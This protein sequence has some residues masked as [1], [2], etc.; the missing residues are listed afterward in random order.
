MTNP[1]NQ[2]QQML[3]QAAAAAAA[4]P[5][6]TP[7]KAPPAKAPTAAAKPAAAPK[8]PPKAPAPPKAVVRE[9]ESA[10]AADVA[11]EQPQTTTVSSTDF[12]TLPDTVETTIT[13]PPL[14]TIE[15]NPEFADGNCFKLS[16]YATGCLDCAAMVAEDPSHELIDRRD[17]NCHYLNGNTHCPAQYFK[18]EFI[19]RRVIWDRKV[20][21]VKELPEGSSER[22]NAAIAL[23][24]KAAKI[25]DDDL[26]N[27]VMYQ[28]GI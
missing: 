24:T 1:T 14:M 20:A 19:G 18:I 27:K 23:M 13:Q 15:P 26:R 21:R 6:A 17:Q 5:K 10:A 28:L 16:L 22:T 3:E 9:E 7:A 2:G 8:A 4:A 25:E 12:N 11:A